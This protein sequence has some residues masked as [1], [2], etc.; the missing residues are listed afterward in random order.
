MLACSAAFWPKHAGVL[1]EPLSF[2]LCAMDPSSVELAEI[3]TLEDIFAWVGV[4]DRAGP[5]S[6][7]FRS[8]L[9][10]A[11]GG[12]QLVRQLVAIPLQSYTSA[13]RELK[14]LVI[15]PALDEAPELKVQRQ[16]TPLE[17]GQVGTVRRVA[18]LVLGLQPDEGALTTN[19][20][21]VADHLGAA[22]SISHLAA[23]GSSWQGGGSSVG[24]KRIKLASVLDQGDDT[25]VR[26]LDPASLRDMVQVWKVTHN[27]GEDPAEEEEAT[28][29][30]LSAL[31]FRL[32]SGATPYVDFAVWRPYGA[33]LGRILKF[34]AFVLISA[35]TYQQKELSGP[36]SFT[37]WGKAWRVFSFAL[38]VLGAAS[39]TRLDKYR[40]RISKLS[41]DYPASW[42]IVAMADMRMRSEHLERIRR[43]ISHEHAELHRAGLPSDFDPDRPWDKVFREAARDN[44]YWHEQVD[45]KALLFAA[46]VQSAASLSDVGVGTLREV[47]SGRKRT[48]EENSGSDLESRPAPKKGKKTVRLT[49]TIHAGQGQG[50]GG[51]RGRGGGAGKSGDSKTPDGRFFR[52]LD[53]KQLCW[54]WNRSVSGCA[55]KCANDRAHKCEW[56]R[57][58]HR[59]VQCRLGNP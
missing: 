51:G 40:E 20:M 39:R 24:V 29:D 57:G 7:D 28:G 49:P 6:T 34:Q 9:L 56:C 1:I 48:A 23:L 55:D 10:R 25:E 52:D 53:G 47:G 11:L 30:Q 41:E 27:D 19:G 46:R 5:P 59:T 44:E 36:C 21:P 35:G 13:L 18:R 54:D 4:V 15:T 45:K 2:I 38:T 42:W 14:V 3:K 26:P 33:R 37:E 16:L 32:K 31:D 50:K 58:P 12:P 22:S 8:G 43:K 17:E